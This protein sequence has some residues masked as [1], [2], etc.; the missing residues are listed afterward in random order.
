MTILTL[1]SDLN[2]ITL[3]GVS[4]RCFNHALRG[5][6]EAEGSVY[7]LKRNNLKKGNIGSSITQNDKKLLDF[8]RQKLR[9]FGIVKGGS[10]RPYKTKNSW[11]LIFSKYDSICLYHYLYDNCGNAFLKRKKSRFEELIEREEEN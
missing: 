4:E 10:I 6:F 2:E 3:Y 8:I 9:E 7:W 11:K 5:F 1:I